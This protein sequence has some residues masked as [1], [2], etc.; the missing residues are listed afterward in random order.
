MSWVAVLR[1]RRRF[2]PGTAAH[3]DR[4]TSWIRDRDRSSDPL[5]RHHVSVREGAAAADLVALGA[6]MLLDRQDDTASATPT[7]PRPLA[8][9]TEAVLTLLERAARFPT[10]HTS[11]A[12]R[13]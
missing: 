6:F 5:R 2:D 8:Q 11:P 1:Y 4:P 10:P 9:S 3:P 12:R 7:L 13:A